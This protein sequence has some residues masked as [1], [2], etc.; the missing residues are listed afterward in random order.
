MNFHI[1]LSETF[2]IYSVRRI[3]IS[4]L[5]AKYDNQT[6]NGPYEVGPVWMNLFPT[7]FE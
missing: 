1:S 6:E 5:A 4:M 7:C 2:K 3:F